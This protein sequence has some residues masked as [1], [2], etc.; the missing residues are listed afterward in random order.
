MGADAPAAPPATSSAA[1]SPIRQRLLS[2]RKK[3][4]A[5]DAQQPVAHTPEN[6]ASTSATLAVESSGSGEPGQVPSST[7]LQVPS[8]SAPEDG[9]VNTSKATLF[10]QRKGNKSSTSQAAVSS[11]T[12]HTIVKPPSRRSRSKPSLLERVFK[13]VPC[14]GFD[15]KAIDD[16]LQPQMVEMRKSEAGPQTATTEGSLDAAVLAPPTINIERPPSRTDSEIIVQPPP[17]SHLLPVDET[18]G[19]TSGAV[20]PPGSTGD[21]IARTHTRDSSEESDGTS[22]TDDDAVVYDEQAHEERLIR[23]GGAGIPLGPDGQPKPLLPPIAPEHIG[24]K[25]LVLDLDE[26]LVHSSFKP[27]PQPDFIVPVEIEFHWHHFHVLKRP[28]VDD[29]LKKM[30][31]IY[32]VVVFTASLSK[33]ADPVLDKL[34]THKAVTHRLFRES[35]FS[36]KGNYVKDLSQLGRPIAD[37]IILDNSPAS[38]IFHVNNAVPVSSWFNDPHDVEL[39]DLIPFLAD[40]ANVPDVRGILNL[41]L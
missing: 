31:E 11:S 1:P 39:T 4:K 29:F 8:S 15:S 12:S 6:S 36:H 35:C 10:Y 20:Q 24:R 37:T 25:C 38:Y 27:I 40:L 22:F 41:A 19:L 5:S 13:L 30:G 26:T 23:N 9:S 32:E 3:N 34:D 2:L 14:V 18:D 7:P 33:Y 16:A 28:G 17:S 21:A